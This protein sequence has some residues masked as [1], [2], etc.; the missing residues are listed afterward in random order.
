MTRKREVP[1]WVSRFLKHAR[2]DDGA[3]AVQFAMM[4]VPMM[5]MV[6]GA[7]D[8][9]RASGEKMRL[10]DA[11]AA[12]A[13]AAARS[14]AT[15]D[16][17]LKPVGDKVLSANLAASKAMLASSTYHPGAYISRLRISH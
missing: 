16:A 7:V 6:F 2:R 17:D 15:I 10:Q 8:V 5:V 3:V 9:S 11:L 13:P 14:T 4:L 1:G 12:A